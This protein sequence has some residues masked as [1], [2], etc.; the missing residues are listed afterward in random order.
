MASCLV[1]IALET[2]SPSRTVYTSAFTRPE[3]R[4]SPRPKQA[5]TEVTFRLPVTGSAVNRMPDACG[6]TICCTTTAI[7]TFRWSMPLR[8]R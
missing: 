1:A 7:W 3:T 4:A 5:S 8:R 2:I 6:K